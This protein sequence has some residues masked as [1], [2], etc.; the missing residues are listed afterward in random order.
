M[1]PSHPE[2]GS[3]HPMLIKLRVHPESKKNKIIQKDNDCFEA[4]V[5]APAEH[6]LANKAV[7]QLLGRQLKMAPGKLR[8]VKG[9]HSRSKIIQA[10]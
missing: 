8:M 6:G 3:T 10:L 2:A 7:L 4:W 9:A 1:P 5:R